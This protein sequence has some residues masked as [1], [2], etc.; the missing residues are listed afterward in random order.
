MDRHLAAPSPHIATLVA[1]YEESAARHVAARDR[2]RDRGRLVAYSRIAAFLVAVG[3]LLAAFLGGRFVGPLV[4]LSAGSFL[5]FLVLVYV[6]SRIDASEQWH[7]ALAHVNEEAAARVAR[8]WDKLPRIPVA[9][10]PPA[11]PY[12]EDLDLFGKASLFQLLGWAGSEA[13]R[14]TLRRWLLEPASPEAVAGRQQAVRELAPLEGFREELAALGRL[15]AP[16]AQH[17]DVFF[18]WAEEEGWLHR[19]AWTL[20]AARL[21][22]LAILV[23]VAADATGLIAG[24]FWLYPMAA[25]LLLSGLHARRTQ[26]TF[27]RVF[28]RQPIFQQNARMFA[29]L[30]DAR[31]T[32]PHLRGLQAR[33]S[34]SGLTAAAE[35]EALDRLK[36][37]SDLRFQALFHF[38]VNALTLWDLWLIERLERWQRRVGRQLREWFQVLGEADALCAIASLAHDNPGWAFPHVDPGATRWAGRDVGHPLLADGQ[39]VVN[40]VELGP[41]G[42]VLLVTGSNMSGKSTLLRSIGVNSIL[43]Q[44]GAPVCA[45]SLSLPPLSIQTSMRVQD[46]LEAGVSYFM[47]AL[48]R[49]KLVVDAAQR[50]PAGPPRLLYLLD[51]ILQGTNTAERQVAV[52]HILQHLLSLPVI[53]A[54]TTHDLELAASPEL[55]PACQSVHFTEGVEESGDTVRL[56]FDYKLRPGVATSRNALKL[57]RLVGLDR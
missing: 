28:S 37:L 12:A 39:R 38:P 16:E 26:A 53:G 40:D 25:G 35:M 48:Q 45:S 22:R 1:S 8:A 9:A 29:R 50:S 34:G 57:L 31:F 18:E 47:A 5:A 3:G 6:H 14:A 33:L 30:A 44:L 10:P 7:D 51:E 54:V 49:L 15:V 13:G 4:A 56:S 36:R 52:R 24:A 2:E 32:S 27:T 20:R 21:L 55:A 19:R 41:P 43:A 23:L 17:L 42:S 46:S 11:H